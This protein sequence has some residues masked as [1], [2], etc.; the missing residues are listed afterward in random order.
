MSADE[1][2][3]PPEAFSRKAHIGS[4]EAYLKEYERSVA[5]PEAY[6]VEQA[7]GFHWYERWHTVSDFNYDMRKG[8]ISI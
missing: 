7:E 4:H 2:Y 6:W 8:P 5:D 1:V 3:S